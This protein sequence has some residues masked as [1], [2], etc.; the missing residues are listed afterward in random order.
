MRPYSLESTLVQISVVDMLRSYHAVL[1]LGQSFIFYIFYKI[2]F[3][4]I[5]ILYLS[6]IYKLVLKKQKNQK[7]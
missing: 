5:K 7:L 4:L 3:K 1:G 2:F 6:E